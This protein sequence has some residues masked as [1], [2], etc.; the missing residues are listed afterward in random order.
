MAGQ[1]RHDEDEAD[2]FSSE[3]R[4]GLARSTGRWA[5]IS[6]ASQLC[7]GR[8]LALRYRCAD[9]GDRRG[10]R[11]ALRPGGRDRQRARLANRL[12]LLVL[13]LALRGSIGRP[14]ASTS[15]TRP[16]RSS[17][18]PRSWRC[19]HLPRVAL[20]DHPNVAEEAIRGW[21]FASVYMVAGR[22]VLVMVG[23]TLQPEAHGGAP[24]LIPGAGRVGHL[25]ARRLLAR[26]PS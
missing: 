8:P 10:S 21:I 19:D 13:T 3:E 4:S 18:G 25:I 14:S 12:A 24:T 22:V 5:E 6:P 16:G 15:S 20:A 7:G 9:A 23:E 26:S 11:D 17:P 2:S 1:S